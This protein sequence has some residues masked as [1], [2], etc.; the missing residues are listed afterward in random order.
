MVKAATAK[1]YEGTIDVL[2]ADVGQRIR[3]ARQERGMSLAQLGGDDLS[4]SFLS[5]VESGRSRISLRALAI[6]AQ[7]LDLP[8]SYFL[9]DD[10]EATQQVAELLLDEAQVALEQG[11]PDDCLQLLGEATGAQVDRVRVLWLRGQA[12]VKKG[13]PREAMTAL[14]EALDQASTGPDVHLVAQI[15]YA[16]GSALYLAGA[17]EEALSQLR[18][19]LEEISSGPGDPTLAG[20]ITVCIG[21]V[22]YVQ[23]DIEGAISHYRQALELFGKV[24]DF[25]TQGCIYSGLSLASKQRGDLTSALRYSRLSVATF[26]AGQNLQ[27]LAAEINNMAMRYLELGDLDQALQIAQSAVD[28]AREVCSAELEATAHSTLASVYMRL[29]DIEAAG[30]EAEAAERLAPNDSS[31]SRVEGW[32]TMAEIAE[33]NGDSTRADLLYQRALESL[34][35]SGQ[36]SAYADTA[37]AYSL[38]LRNRGNTERALELALEAARSRSAS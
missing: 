37:L 8:M 2:A 31:L 32:K 7:K 21:H 29:G 6:V 9:A 28:R 27:Q 4:R 16:L 15:R 14:Q 20:K 12:L 22:L 33:R 34:E 19:A 10:R 13:K 35:N 18:F 38:L 30:V 26:Q 3:R 17:Y 1:R 5:L 23:R 24:R 11:R 36:R 25:Y